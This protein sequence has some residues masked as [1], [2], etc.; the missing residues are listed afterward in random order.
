MS[1]KDLVERFNEER[2]K[3][4]AAMQAELLVEFRAL[5]DR[6]PNVQAIRWV[7]YTPS[8]NDGEACEFTCGDVTVRF[9]VP[10][11]DEECDEECFESWIKK[12]SPNFDSF[13]QIRGLHGQIPGEVQLDMFGNNVQ[14]T[15]TRDGIEVEDYDCD[16]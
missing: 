16:Y 10:E 2:A 13:A 4:M 6:N 14:V 3:F 15:V 11:D 8:W 5:L 9:D 7:Q 12:D 1:M